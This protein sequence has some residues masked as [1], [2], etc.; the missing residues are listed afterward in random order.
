MY[1]IFDC[2]LFFQSQQ[3]I[4]LRKADKSNRAGKP[5]DQFTRTRTVRGHAGPAARKT[6]SL[7]RE[8]RLTEK[9]IGA[10][11]LMFTHFFPPVPPS[12]LFFSVA[13]FASLTI[14]KPE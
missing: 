14:S 7:T 5:K 1:Q 13:I 9:L 3:D 2:T 10:V 8:R 11:V 12:H 6:N 4:M